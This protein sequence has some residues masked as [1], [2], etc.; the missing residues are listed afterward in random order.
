MTVFI[1]SLSLNQHAKFARAKIFQTLQS[2]DPT[3][4]ESHTGMKVLT[5]DEYTQLQSNLDSSRREARQMNS[6]V[7]LKFSQVLETATAVEKMKTDI[8][9]LKKVIEEK[10]KES[11]KK[12]GEADAVMEKTT[13]ADAAKEA[14]SEV[15]ND[16]K[17]KTITTNEKNATTDSEMVAVDD[18]A[19]TSRQ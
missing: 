13:D 17:E 18:A 12:S 8:E 16:G 4:I 1:T 3:I 9:E 11:D 7:Q 10:E 6:K 19:K 14:D 2:M 5:N 15:D